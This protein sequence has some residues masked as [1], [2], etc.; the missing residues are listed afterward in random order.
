[1]KL[2]EPGPFILHHIQKLTQN[3]LKTQ[4]EGHETPKPKI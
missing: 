3:E 2:N 1:M 4:M